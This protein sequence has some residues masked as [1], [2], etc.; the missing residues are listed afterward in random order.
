MVNHQGND[1]GIMT[2]VV[3]FDR[4]SINNHS[5]KISAMKRTI[6]IFLS[7]IVLISACGGHTINTGS[8]L[9]PRDTVIVPEGLTG[10][11]SIAYIENMIVKS[12]I[13]AT[14]LLRLAEVHTV[15]DRLFH[16]YEEAGCPVYDPYSRE[17]HQTERR[18]SA[19]MSLAN[20]LIR[21]AELVN[22]NGDANDKLQWAVAVNAA[23]DSFHVAVPSLP[24]DSVI[25]DISRV[26]SKFSNDTQSE[27]NFIAY[28]DATVDYYRTIEAYRQW[29]SEVPSNLKFLMQNEY[30]AWHNFNEARFAFWRDVSYNQEWY[31]MKPMEIEGYYE[32]L[33]A[34]RRA[35]LEE[36]RSIIL[37]GKPYFPKGKTITSA[38][39]EKWITDHS[40]PEDIEYL[41]NEF[42]KDRIPN[43]SIVNNRVNALKSTFSQ[44]IEARSAIVK[45]LPQEQSRWYDNMT[46]DIFCRLV[47][48]LANII[49]IEEL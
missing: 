27:L 30:V 43:D 14:D 42:W 10:E 48:R 19:A 47:G 4:Y 16:C 41:R 29:L 36:E 40:V 18:D 7:A 25:S 20:Q 15:Q 34:N 8:N 28:V 22:L 21:M 49:P 33:S 45:A 9:D 26:V 37:E 3:P 23:I 46:T 32:N 1:Y 12:P 11:D 38:Q 2:I 13:S 44:W 5:I 31:S 17:D 6:Y 24:I 35:E 39:W